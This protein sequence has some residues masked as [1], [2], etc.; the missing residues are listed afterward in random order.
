MALLSRLDL[1]LLYIHCQSSLYNN[2]ASFINSCSATSNYSTP[3]SWMLPSHNIHFFRK[4]KNILLTYSVLLA[5]LCIYFIGITSRSPLG[6]HD[7]LIAH[8]F[9]PNIS[10]AEPISYFL[11]KIIIKST[12]NVDN[13]SL[14]SPLFGIF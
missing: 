4:S 2:F 1:W 11:Y 8:A 7:L 13:L 3:H 14:I 6:D 10:I 12:G 5:I 9:N